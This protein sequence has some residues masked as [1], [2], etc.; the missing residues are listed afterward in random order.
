MNLY[1]LTLCPVPSTTLGTLFHII[2]T[3]ILEGR[4]EQP[5]YLW[6]I[7]DSWR[8]V[9]FPVSY[10]QQEPGFKFRSFWF[11]NTSSLCSPWVTKSEVRGRGKAT[12]KSKA[13]CKA[14][15]RGKDC[16]KLENECPHENIL[17]QNFTTL[18]VN[19]T[20]LSIHWIW[21]VSHQIL[22]FLYFSNLGKKHSHT[23]SLCDHMEEAENILCDLVWDSWDEWVEVKERGFWSGVF[24]RPSL[25][26]CPAEELPARKQ[27]AVHQGSERNKYHSTPRQGF[28][29]WVGDTGLLNIY[30]AGCSRSC[31]DAEPSWRLRPG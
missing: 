6:G 22:S 20:Y 21:L 23:I 24:N 10:G 9:H 5:S 15:G 1:F 25:H 27:Q 19:K 17:V 16:G 12:E 7:C 4:W 2:V 8:L 3:A 31:R 26:S 30:G 14:V 28:L 29:P 11:Q 13:E 18:Q